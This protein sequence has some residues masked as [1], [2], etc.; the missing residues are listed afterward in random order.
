MIA[1][2]RRAFLGLLAAPA[3]LRVTKPMALW[4]PPS[5]TRWG[6]IYSY[7]EGDIFTT[8]TIREMFLDAAG[9]L[10]QYQFMSLQWQELFNKGATK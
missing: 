8:P 5:V 7:A 4:V 2:N 10:R 3:V 9:V 1:T 6:E